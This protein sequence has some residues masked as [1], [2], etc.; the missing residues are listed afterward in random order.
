MGSILI[1]L[2][3]LETQCIQPSQTEYQIMRQSTLAVITV[4]SLAGTSFVN[5]NS[6]RG[7]TSTQGNENDVESV[8]T[9]GPPGSSVVLTDGSADSAYGT[10][11][12][13]GAD[14][15]VRSPPNVPF[16]QGRRRRQDAH[17]IV[18]NPTMRPSPLTERDIST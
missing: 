7:H 1:P 13:F 15:I 18:V 10:V 17:E 8:F 3:N 2:V 5:S 6:M 12:E 11:D 9:N 16:L 14:G 4:A